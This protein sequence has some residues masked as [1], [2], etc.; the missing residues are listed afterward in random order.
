MGRL[1]VK[2]HTFG[3]EADKDF[4]RVSVVCTDTPSKHDCASMYMH[5]KYS[6]V[7]R[8]RSR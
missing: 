4:I 6:V 8:A 7:D 2:E 3:R 5:G 1:T